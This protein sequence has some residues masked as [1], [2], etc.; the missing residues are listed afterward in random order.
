MAALFLYGTLRDAELFSI[1]AGEGAGRARPARLP[2][3]AAERVMG[4]DLP[5]LVRR[6][7]A[8]AEGLLWEGLDEARRARL[9]R[10]ELPWGYRLGEALVEVEG[11]A[12]PAEVYLPPEEQTSTGTPWSLAAWQAG[13]APRI[14]LAAA[15]M[16][17]HEPPLPPE[18][19]RRQWR[20]MEVR[21]DAQLRAA[22][23][24][25]PTT[26]RHSPAPGDFTLRASAP[27]HGSFFKLSGLDIAHRRFDG[28]RETGVPR[29]VFTGTDAALVLPH[30]PDTGLVLMVEQFRPGPAKRGDPNPWVLEPVAGIIDPGETPKAAARREA[31][32]EAGVTLTSLRHLFSFYPSP[33]TN[34]DFFHC[35][36]G[37]TRLEKEDLWY[38]G[39]EEEREDIRV[40]VVSLERALGL[41]RSGEI[42]IGPL[43]AM[44]MAL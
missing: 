15:E 16:A 18:E 23:E 24:P 22:R 44:L 38:G 1:V 2:G 41:V 39:L 19:L 4:V 37:E 42:N 6:E 30:D 14:R 32:E 29:E 26:L 21:A 20:M 8:A 11:G 40:H 17:A 27:P 28:G 43:I 5:M 13:D 36:A 9:D 34:T 10:F 35:Y 25:A 31:E 12:V 33:G 7:G 3:W